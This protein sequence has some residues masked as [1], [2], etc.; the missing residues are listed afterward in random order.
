MELTALLEVERH[1]ALD[2]GDMEPMPTGAFG[3]CVLERTAEEEVRGNGQGAL[4][5]GW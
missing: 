1:R 2:S 5:R 3:F 4:S